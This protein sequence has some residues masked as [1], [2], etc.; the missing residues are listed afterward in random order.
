M[1]LAQLLPEDV[2]ADVLS[3]VPPRS[4]AACRC[5]CKPLRSVIDGR[6]LLRTD[7]LPLS[8][9]GIFLNFFDIVRPEFF[10]RP[11][12]GPTISGSLDYVPPSRQFGGHSFVSSR[13]SINAIHSIQDH[14]NGLLLLED[15]VV[16]PATQQWDPLPPCP[17]RYRESYGDFTYEE[18][19]VFDP[20]V[21]P[22]Y[23]DINFFYK[24][25]KYYKEHDE[26]DEG[27]EY[28]RQRKFELNCN[29]EEL[30]QEKFE[31][32]SEDDDL[33]DVG[34]TVGPGFKGCTHILGFHPFK[35]G[36]V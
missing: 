15:C 8:V 3:R 34:D 26:P 24:C 18:Y 1:D 11:S 19:L 9:G 31:W 5:V 27:M 10:S 35:E 32:D 16:N 21:S 36:K 17:A 23:E 28:L 30:V 2:L 20:M 33:L 22:H 29:K 12:A 25:V 6:Q 4:L 13:R 7:L 14:C